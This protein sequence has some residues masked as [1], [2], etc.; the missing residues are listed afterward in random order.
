MAEPLTAV[1][2]VSWAPWRRDARVVAVVGLAHFTSH[3]F[4]L[5][6][7]PLFPWLRN[8]FGVS[9][10]ELGFV[11]TVLFVVSGTSQALAGF[12]VDRFGAGITLVTGLG[13]LSLAAFGFGLSHTYLQLL[14]CATL[15]GLGN[16]VFHPVDFSVL[17]SR[18]SV[19][20][21]GPAYSV[22]GLTGNLG[23]AL[24]PVFLVGIAMPYGWR[25]AVAG[26]G[27]LPLFAIA[28]VISN[29]AFLVPDAAAR[30]TH[31]IDGPALG[32]LRHGA[33]WWCFGFFFIVAAAA[34][35]VQNFAPSILGAQYHLSVPHAALSITLFMLASA[36]GMLSGGWLVMRTQRLERNI[37]IAFTL[38]VLGAMAI[39]LELVP[40]PVALAAIGVM[41]FGSGLSGPS[42][43]MLIRSA[44]PPGAT[45]RV[46]GVVY[47]GLDLGI[48]LAPLAFGKMLDH[49]YFAQ[50]FLGVAACLLAAMLAA[51]RVAAC[52][53]TTR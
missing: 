6:V 39:G 50:V 21:L 20:R 52:P 31:G 22:H 14:A 47:S 53:V 49:G 27:V 48:A 13:C 16:G 19:G 1:G 35:G 15:A 36:A 34:A 2:T 29:R 5:I 8:E 44:T 38:S 18:V 11:T 7:V 33:I 17:N 10:A 45:G 12:V 28:L 9:Y 37:T 46:Y 51:W 4:Q 25:A 26:A 41:G 24:A 42:R 32:F 40:A 3:F 43:D 23:W 30:G